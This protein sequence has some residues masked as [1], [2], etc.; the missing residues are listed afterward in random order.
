MALQ[1]KPPRLTRRDF[2]ELLANH[3]AI[4]LVMNALAGTNWAGARGC[5]AGLVRVD[6]WIA[7]VYGRFERALATWN[8]NHPDQPLLEATLEEA[9]ELERRKQPPA[10]ASPASE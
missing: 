6:R 1:F 7:D 2:E 9:A 8:A 5:E 3:K 10:A 4:D